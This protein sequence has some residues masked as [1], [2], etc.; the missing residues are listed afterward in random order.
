MLKQIGSVMLVSAIALIT[1]PANAQTCAALPVVGGS[2]ARVQKTVS[3]PGAGPVVRDNWN[4]DF[5]V[6]R[7]GY[8]SYV[9]TITPK[10]SGTY[11]ILMN[12]KY[13]NDSVD[14][15]F[16]EKV[17]LKQ[18]QPYRIQGTTRIGSTP[19][20]VNLS[21]GGVEAIGNTYVAS[22]AGCR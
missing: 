6:G 12:L 3:P 13:S 7:Q 16:D 5:S 18:G 20:Q 14:K 19:Y 17:V 15:V 10:N 2:G 11:T 8:R 22:V 9:A 4:T 1:S 21:V